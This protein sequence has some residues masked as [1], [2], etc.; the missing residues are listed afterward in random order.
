M[1]E[2]KNT[3][4][5]AFRGA[6]VTLSVQWCHGRPFPAPRV[7]SKPVESAVL[8]SARGEEEKGRKAFRNSN[9]GKNGGKK[10]ADK[11][12]QRT[13]RAQC[14]AP[15]NWKKRNDRDRSSPSLSLSLCSPFPGDSFSP[16]SGIISR[17][18]LIAVRLGDL[19]PR[20]SSIDSAANPIFYAHFRRKLPP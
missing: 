9:R 4:T 14:R 1:F 13:E 6:S 18:E 19:E 11:D 20:R 10:G 8:I 5:D 15:R 12:S 2:H 3:R 16:R 7:I 17:V